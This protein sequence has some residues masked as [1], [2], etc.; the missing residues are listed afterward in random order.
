MRCKSNGFSR[1][2]LFQKRLIALSGFIASALRGEYTWGRPFLSIQIEDMPSPGFL[3]SSKMINQA[4]QGSP[5]GRNQIL[6]PIENYLKKSLPPHLRGRSRPS[7]YRPNLAQHTQGYM[8]L[9]SIPAYRRRRNTRR[10]RRVNRKTRR[11]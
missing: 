5:Q 1:M 8:T 7:M 2:I 4:Q 11:N 3:R 9:D 10:N 6:R